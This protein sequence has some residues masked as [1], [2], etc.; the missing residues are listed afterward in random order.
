MRR[1]RNRLLR[2]F[3]FLL[4]VV[5]GLLIF[6]EI[7]L[8]PAIQSIAE[9]KTKLA[10]TKIINEAVSRNTIN[11]KYGDIM[12]IH[13]DS[14]DRVVLMMPNT[15][16]INQLATQTTLEIERDLNDLKSQGIS[17]PLGLITGSALLSNT[18][19]PLKVEV[20]P[21]GTVDV[22][23]MDEFVEAGINQT[24]HRIFFNIKTDLKVVVPMMGSTI[25]ISMQV[26]VTE[27][28]I[29][30]PVPEWYMKFTS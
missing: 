1:N 21:V 8:A 7:N 28:I 4:F 16:V 10:A 15:R 19:P 20:V 2:N 23:V 27:S 5:F 9:A 6:L 29:I 12:D 3:C 25:N 30:G 13:K 11:N 26:P 18:G 24:K 17:I 22:D 14:Q